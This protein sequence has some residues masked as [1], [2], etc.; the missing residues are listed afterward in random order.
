MKTIEVSTAS[1]L[2]GEYVKEVDEGG[3]VLTLND[4]PIA[5]LVSLKKID[6][7]SLAL[8]TNAEFLEVIQKARAE[9]KAGKKISLEELKREILQ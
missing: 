6:K 9:F 8:S 5:A 2:L 3:I 7:E 4:E 1:K